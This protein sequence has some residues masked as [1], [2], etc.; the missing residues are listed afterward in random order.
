MITNIQAKPYNLIFVP[1]PRLNQKSEPVLEV[2]DEIRVIMDRLLATIHA[3]DGIGI[4]AVQV[5]ILKRIVVI[6][7]DG[8]Y[9][10][11]P[12]NKEPEVHGGKPL[13][14]I[15]P[16]IIEASNDKSSMDEGCMSVPGVYV[17]IERPNTVSVRFLDYDGKEQTLR[18]EKGLLSACIQHEIDHAN[19]ITIIDGLS[20][21]KKQMQLKKVDK[22]KKAKKRYEENS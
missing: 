16:E 4:T 15:N 17:S 21:L 14:M 10:K 12:N 9:K 18:V 11:D 22:F 7:I 3:N 20:P 19:G 13:F 1:D 6:D 8:A 5:G 2:N